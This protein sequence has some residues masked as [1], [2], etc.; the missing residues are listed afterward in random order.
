MDWRPNVV[1]I[2][3][4]QVARSRSSDSRRGLSMEHEMKMSP[5]TVRRL[6]TECGWSQE[7][8]AIA[9]GLSLRTIQRVEAEGI[10]SMG[11]AVS[12]AATYGVK[13][14]ELQEGQSEQADGKPARYGTLFLGLAVITLAM[15]G[16]S[17]RLPGPMSQGLAALNIL[18]AVVGAMLAVP[19]LFHVFRQRQ[20]IGGA[21]AVLGTPL[22]TLLAGG[23]VFALVSG[24]PPSWQLGGIGAAGA[25]L[26][27]M[28]AREL[29]R[30][31][32][33]AAT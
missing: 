8:L 23:T 18:A 15:V 16:E 17:G 21:L 11:T 29:R 27:A 28:A 24:Q 12:L 7:Q 1:L 4:L 33:T 20:Y 19:T 2:N 32:K 10:A 26:V 25:A 22:V 5:S 9:S 14:I 6:R 13:L 3:W 30:G 31:P